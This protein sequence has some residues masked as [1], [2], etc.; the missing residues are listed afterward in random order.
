M[1]MGY[2]APTKKALKTM[3]GEE[4]QPI[5]TSMFGQEYK[6]D[7]DYVVVGPDP[8][9]ARNYFAKVSVINGKIT[10]VV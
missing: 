9:R 6:G 5:E 4:F 2:D 3:I 10:K 7:G 1:T 8:Y